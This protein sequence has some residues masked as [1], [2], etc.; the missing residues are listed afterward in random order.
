MKEKNIKSDLL[1][2]LL[3]NLLAC[4]GIIQDGEETT[5]AGQDF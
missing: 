4:K 2:S 3:G 1:A 5:K